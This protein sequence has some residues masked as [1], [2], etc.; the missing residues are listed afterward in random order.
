MLVPLAA[1]PIRA[2]LE[3]LPEGVEG[4][5]A[6]LNL[7]ARLARAGKKSLPVRLAAQQLTNHLPQKDWLAEVAELHRFVRD[8]I[9]Y[10]R[11]VRGV[12]TVQAPERTL[13][14]KSGDCDDKATLLAA[15]LESI[16]HPARF[17]AIGFRRGHF[18]HVFPETRIGRRWLALETTEPWEVGE[19]AADRAA[20][21]LV[22]HV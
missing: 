3:A 20:A 16:G 7:M 13:Q 6:T 9:R 10:V 2:T 17:H 19:S 4:V 11:D 1:T 5:R 15:L 14:L 12:E 18:S 21:H 8:R 22:V